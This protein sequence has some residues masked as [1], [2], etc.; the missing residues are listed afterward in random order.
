MLTKYSV[1]VRACVR[2][3]EKTKY[4]ES[5]KSLTTQKKW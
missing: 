4:V 3:K 5:L 2:A 1:R